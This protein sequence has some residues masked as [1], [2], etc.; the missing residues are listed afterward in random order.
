MVL[1]QES[2]G[3]GTFYYLV[4]GIRED[5]GY[6]GT[7]GALLGDRIAPKTIAV[8]RNQVIVDYLDRTDHEAMATPP[9]HPRQRIF[10]Y[11]PAVG[12]LVALPESID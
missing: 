4:V 5:D 9:S 3:S 12:R 8:K 7:G 2:G 1:I 10:S 6:R 11:E